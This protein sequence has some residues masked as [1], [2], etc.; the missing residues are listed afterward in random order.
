M[1]TKQKYVS[2]FFAAQQTWESQRESSTSTS[3]Q[4]NLQSAACQKVEPPFHT[5]SFNYSSVLFLRCYLIGFNSSCLKSRCI[6]NYEL[7]PGQS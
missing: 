5:E 4:H 2:D 6:E 7:L 1:T 3:E